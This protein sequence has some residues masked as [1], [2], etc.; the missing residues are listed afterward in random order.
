M[1]PNADA[2]AAA[3]VAGAEESPGPIL[4]ELEREVSRLSKDC[5]R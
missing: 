1:F 5:G 3:R 2:S 4:P